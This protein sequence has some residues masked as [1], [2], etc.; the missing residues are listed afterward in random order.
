MNA[1][2]WVLVL[3]GVAVAGFGWMR[4]RAAVGK[5]A[6]A[7]GS[8]REVPGTLHE[9]AVREDAVWDSEADKVVEYYPAVRY[10]Y[11]AAG[12]EH[13]GSRAFLSRAKFDSQNH[14]QA[15]QAKV[16]PG[17]VSVWHDPADPTSS[18]LELDRPSNSGLVVAAI[19]AVI[20]IGVGISVL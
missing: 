13:E 11:Q 14:A 16:R 3:A 20:L 8:W 12:R 2:G 7:A 10:S 4:H 15:W 9:A 18:A 19:F 1:I 6:A 5:S 17:P